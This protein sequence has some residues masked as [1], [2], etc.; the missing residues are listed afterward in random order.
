MYHPDQNNFFNIRFHFAGFSGFGHELS[1]QGWEISCFRSMEFGSYKFVLRHRSCCL[2]G[3]GDLAMDYMMSKRF[4]SYRES[5]TRNVYI[6]MISGGT[7]IRAMSHSVND[8]LN[9][10]R[11]HSD[12]FYPVDVSSYQFVTAQ[13]IFDGVAFAKINVSEDFEI[14]LNKKDEKEILNLLFSKQDHKQK[15]IRQNERRRS[16]QNGQEPF[17]IDAEPA[18]ALLRVV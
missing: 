9:F 6:E 10:V 18:K 15:E 1:G 14:Y 3:Y 11:K 16:W 8:G 12:Q 17:K 2:Y 4:E 7:E 13:Q 5:N